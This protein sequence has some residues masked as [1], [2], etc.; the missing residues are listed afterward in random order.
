MLT[1]L[2]NATAGFGAICCLVILSL[3][4][5]SFHSRF[6]VFNN[7]SKF[8]LYCVESW[9]GKLKF[10]HSTNLGKH[11]EFNKWIIWAIPDSR[12]QKDYPAH[13]LD[14]A[15]SSFDIEWTAQ[16]RIIAMPHWA[17]AILV[18]ICAFWIKPKPKSQ[19]RFADMFL[20]ITIIAILSGAFYRLD[21]D[22]W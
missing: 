17:L 22:Q 15:S 9:K 19:F 6:E 10:Q 18:G 8:E 20:L 12:M 14:W 21:Y 2:R 4:A 7:V 13:S 11:Y 5:Y 1:C 16:D 3:W